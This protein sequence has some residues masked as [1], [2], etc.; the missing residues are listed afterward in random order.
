MPPKPKRPRSPPPR[1]EDSILNV[2]DPRPQRVAQVPSAT[3][4]AGAARRFAG[5]RGDRE[6]QATYGVADAFRPAFLYV[7]RGPGQG[8]L[9]E[10]R[11]G[12]I[13]IGRASVADLRLQHP[14]I[15]RRHAQ[16]TRVGEQFFVKD[17][18]SQNGTLVN[19]ERLLGE[20]ELVP[21]D[22]LCVGSAELR[23]RGPLSKAEQRGVAEDRAHPGASDGAGRRTAVRQLGLA[24][25]AAAVGFGLAA[26][27]GFGLRA[28][29]PETPTVTGP[30]DRAPPPSSDDAAPE[31]EAAP[32]R[33][34]GPGASAADP[35]RAAEV[36]PPRQPRGTGRPAPEVGSRAAPPVAA[37]AP[38]TPPAR[39]PEPLGSSLSALRSA[40]STE[41]TGPEAAPALP[42]APPARNPIDDAFDGR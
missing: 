19:R 16:V 29:S 17:L 38:S 30:V 12:T 22:L 18:G 7:E 37:P 39:A 6:L 33:P 26:V 8:Q 20:L 25:F 34:A 13:V 2:D 42:V 28:S 36:V 24:I 41:R 23:L 27:L 3:A 14:S 31:P 9:L 32:P 40:P 10:V 11:P 5:A 4:T 35:A 15:S 21:G 1:E